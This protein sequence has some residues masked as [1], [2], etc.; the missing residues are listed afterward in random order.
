MI[1][2]KPSVSPWMTGPSDVLVSHAGHVDLEPLCAGFRL[3]QS[4]R[5]RLGDRVEMSGD[6]LATTDLRLSL[7]PHVVLDGFH[8]LDAARHFDRLVNVG[9]RT[10]EAA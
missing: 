2:A 5:G 4:D 9:S 6:Q 3:Q 10:D 8:T 7:Q 1:L